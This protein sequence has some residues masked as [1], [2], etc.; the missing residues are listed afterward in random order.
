M[1]VYPKSIIGF[2]SN[3]LYTLRMIYKEARVATVDFNLKDVTKNQ[4]S[5]LIQAN[6][7]RNGVEVIYLL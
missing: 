1:D 7:V 5:K 6:L 3:A 2:N 4:E